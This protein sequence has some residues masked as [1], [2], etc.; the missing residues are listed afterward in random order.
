MAGADSR[1]IA[2]LAYDDAPILDVVGPLDVFSHA[3]RLLVDSG[4][5][6]R[7]PYDIKVVSEPRGPICTSSGSAIEAE[8]SFHSIK[9]GIDT[10]LIADGAGFRKSE[11]NVGLV[12]WICRESETARRLG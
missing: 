11:E 7:P 9:G 1:K 12:D 2:M 4:R 3:S 10:L 8:S 5:A 6:D